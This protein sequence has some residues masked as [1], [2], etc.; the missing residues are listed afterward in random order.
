[1]FNQKM[2]NDLSKENLI[3]LCGRFEGVDERVLQHH[4][5]LEISIGDFVLSGGEI[6]ALT[7]LDACVRLIDG[8]MGGQ[9]SAKDESFAISGDF[10][11]LLEY[12]QYTKPPIWND[13]KIPQVL[14]SGN[15]E[16]IKKWRLHQSFDLTKRLR[17]DL[18]TANKENLK[19]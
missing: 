10:A 12:P 3:L 16:K 9:D 13:V 1:V 15:H 4:N 7:I 5:P 19:E 11:G 8:V 17:P 6:A 14:L 2:A 18:C